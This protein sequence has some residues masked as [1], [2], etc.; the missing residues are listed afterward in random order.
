MNT[1]T[2]AQPALQ[3]VPSDVENE[4]AIDSW[5]LP[6]NLPAGIFISPHKFKGERFWKFDEKRLKP[7]PVPTQLL[8]D[9]IEDYREFPL[10]TYIHMRW[11]LDNQEDMP[12]SF[13]E[14]KIYF[15]TD[16][17]SR[18][19]GPCAFIYGI[20]FKEGEWK[21]FEA[22]LDGKPGKGSRFLMAS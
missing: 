9:T 2:S 6:E 22:R 10:L 14:F 8:S 17:F 20:E 3:S 4:G 7:F 18:V 21:E 16:S 15:P 12:E 5:I 13:R 1:K 11:M 19:N